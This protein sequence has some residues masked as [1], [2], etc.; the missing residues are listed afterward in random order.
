MVENKRK[1]VCL[2]E[3]VVEKLKIWATICRSKKKKSDMVGNGRIEC[4]HVCG[5][6]ENRLKEVESVWLTEASMGYS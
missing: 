5:A 4:L 6:P 3:C 1:S 2:V